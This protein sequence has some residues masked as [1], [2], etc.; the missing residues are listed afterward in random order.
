MAKIIKSVSTPDLSG[1]PFKK[2][3]G[4]SSEKLLP[5]PPSVERKE[6]VVTPNPTTRQQHQDNAKAAR[7][8][9]AL[10]RQLQAQPAAGL[11]EVRPCA[12][13]G[14]SDTQARR[15]RRQKR[16]MNKLAVSLDLAAGKITKAD[17]QNLLQTGRNRVNTRQQF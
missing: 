11:R 6:I 7:H 1:E 15:R 17:A 12:S 3:F 16:A 9:D 10:E 2:A 8:Q 14:L 5:P 13:S 4:L